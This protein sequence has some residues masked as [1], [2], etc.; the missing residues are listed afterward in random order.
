MLFVVITQMY[1]EV[2]LFTYVTQYW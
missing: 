1:Q 2:L